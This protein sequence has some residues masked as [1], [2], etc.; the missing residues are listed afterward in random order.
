MKSFSWAAVGHADNPWNRNISRSE[1]PDLNWWTSSAF[2]RTRHVLHNH[3]RKR[4]RSTA[5]E[6]T[7]DFWCANAVAS[8]H[9]FVS[10]YSFSSVLCY[11]SETPTLSFTPSLHIR[12]GS[13]ITSSFSYLKCTW[14]PKHNENEYF[15]TWKRRKCGWIE[16]KWSV[17]RRLQELQC[18]NVL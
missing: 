2:D 12:L 3:A 7:S 9:S 15:V 13:A 4:R 5:K 18:T 6:P 17:L 16:W 14:S 1:L 10:D 11:S 8:Q